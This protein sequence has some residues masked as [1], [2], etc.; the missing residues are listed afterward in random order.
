MAP[1]FG[2]KAPAQSGLA[3]HNYSVLHPIG[4]TKCLAIVEESDQSINI[5]IENIFNLNR[6]IRSRAHK[7]SFPPVA[8]SRKFVLD[9]VGQQGSYK[10]IELHSGQVS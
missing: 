8:S 5:F 2:E 4:K 3:K 6:A 10:L 9:E 7:V 1:R